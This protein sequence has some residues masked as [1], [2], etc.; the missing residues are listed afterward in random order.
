MPSLHFTIHHQIAK[1]IDVLAIEIESDVAI[2]FVHSQYA[3]R[4]SSRLYC[5]V[6]PSVGSACDTSGYDAGHLKLIQHPADGWNVRFF[7][8]IQRSN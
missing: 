8:L 5:R 3:T 6:A 4:I 1:A 2:N 7:T